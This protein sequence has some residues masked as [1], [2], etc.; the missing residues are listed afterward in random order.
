MLSKNAIKYYSTL[1]NK[2]YRD[3][4]RKFIVEG[5]RLL[6]EALNSKFDP[7]LVVVTQS[8]FDEN[9]A[10][11]GRI[12]QQAKTEIVKEVDFKRL[13]DTKSPQGILGVFSKGQINFVFEPKTNFVLAL[14]NISDP[15]N[16]G[17]I[18]RN[19]DWFG[20]SEILLSE[21]C[22][23]LFNPK[24]L[25]ASMGSV[26]HVDLSDNSDFYLEIENMKK[27]GYKILLADMTGEN[28]YD[29]KKSKKV[30]L[31]LSNEAHGPT[32]SIIRFS[33]Q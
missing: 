4:E 1:L 32:Q 13:S 27:N 9:E 16:L 26:F 22:A 8:Y 11:V 21:D 28:I 19:A 30:I 23:D 25:R 7:E 2:K 33:R 20:V 5:K 3:R 12:S 6:E 24:V 14:E 31:V 15:G 17:T 18:I 29:Y 10:E